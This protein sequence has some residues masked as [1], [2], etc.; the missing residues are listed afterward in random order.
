MRKWGKAANADLDEGKGV[1]NLSFHGASYPLYIHPVVYSE[2]S[3]GFE[4]IED[5]EKAIRDAASR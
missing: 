4:R 3:I 5:F 2:V 1:R